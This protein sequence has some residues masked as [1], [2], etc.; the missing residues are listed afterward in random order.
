MFK[1]PSTSLFFCTGDFYSDTL[2]YVADS[3]KICP[4]GSY[5]A[6]D[7]N[8]GKS[9]LDC[10]TCPDGNNPACTFISITYSLYFIHINI[11]I[12]HL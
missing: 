8:P 4:N 9:V 11:R 7:K 2:G 5:V 12:Y 6:Y 3:C 1:Q 10:K